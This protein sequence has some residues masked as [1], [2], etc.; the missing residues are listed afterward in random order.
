MYHQDSHPWPPTLPPISIPL[1]QGAVATSSS[2]LVVV[3]VVVVFRRNGNNELFHLHI[4]LC[5]VLGAGGWQVGPRR[6]ALCVSYGVGESE[7]PGSNGTA[8]VAGV[9]LH[10]AMV[11]GITCA[12]NVPQDVDL[13]CKNK[14]KVLVNTI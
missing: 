5:N 14:W 6:A 12:A 2:G 11:I 10:A 7:S 8:A 1:L 4:S 3:V 13:I 9:G